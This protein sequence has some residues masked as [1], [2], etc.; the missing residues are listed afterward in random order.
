MLA[1]IGEEH[2]LEIRTAD[3]QDDS[4]R[5]QQFSRARQGH[6]D[7]VATQKQAVK[8]IGYIILEVLPAQRKLLHV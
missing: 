4:M 6:V 5:V 2:L 8:S 7:E 1:R 3:G